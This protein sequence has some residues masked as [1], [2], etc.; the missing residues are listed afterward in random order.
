MYWKH[1]EDSQKRGGNNH[2]GEG[3]ALTVIYIIFKIEPAREREEE[4]DKLKHDVH[5]LIHIIIIFLNVT[6]Q[7]GI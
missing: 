3:T 4:Y 5:I 1:V 6:F 2:G 7:K